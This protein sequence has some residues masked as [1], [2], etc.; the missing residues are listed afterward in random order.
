MER[1]SVH[2]VWSHGGP[3]RTEWPD[4]HASPGSVPRP[5]T[6][7]T[8]LELCDVELNVADAGNNIQMSAQAGDVGPQRLQGGGRAALDLTDARLGQPGG[9]GQLDLGQA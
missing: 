2:D 8:D 4:L 5:P 7:P 6:E 9:L 3:T 1:P